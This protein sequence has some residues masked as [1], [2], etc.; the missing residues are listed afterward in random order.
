[1]ICP[2]PNINQIMLFSPYLIHGCS[3]NNN[4]NITRISLEMRF[5]KNDEKGLKQE[6]EFN[7]FL[8]IRDWR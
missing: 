2:N 4:D 8:K 5:I 1:M 7:K 3:N 6:F